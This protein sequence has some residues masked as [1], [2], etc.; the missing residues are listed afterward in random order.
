VCAVNDDDVERMLIDKA[1]KEPKDF[2]GVVRWRRRTTSTTPSPA[3]P[4]PEAATGGTQ[5][6]CAR[7]GAR[8]T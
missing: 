7:R 8:P 5:R 4:H 3:V 1:F 2:S 6:T